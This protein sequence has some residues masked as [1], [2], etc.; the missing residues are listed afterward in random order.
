MAEDNFRARRSSKEKSKFYL[1]TK[2]K[3]SPLSTLQQTTHRC[4]RVIPKGVGS[5]KVARRW[6]FL[7]G[8]SFKGEGE[9]TTTFT[10]G[11]ERE[12]A[13]R[14]FCTAE[15]TPTMGRA[16][17]IIFVGNAGTAAVWKVLSS[18]RGAAD[19]I[20]VSFGKGFLEGLLL[21]GTG[22]PVGTGAL[23]AAVKGYGFSGVLPLEASI[24]GATLT[25]VRSFL[26]GDC[27]VGVE[28]LETD[29]GMGTAMTGCIGTGNNDKW[30]VEVVLVAEFSEITALECGC[31]GVTKGLIWSN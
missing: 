11:L 27:F 30:M 6:G 26:G 7:V 3:K 19:F 16:F 25:F 5:F 8:V 20:A 10:V 24:S 22:A 28:L 4:L 9:G 18:A 17:S 14:R 31:A 2:E 21:P 29:V 15:Q 1:D 23:V 13:G 12:S